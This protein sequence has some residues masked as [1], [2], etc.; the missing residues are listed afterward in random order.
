M[1]LTQFCLLFSSLLLL[2]MCGQQ[3]FQDNPNSS[4]VSQGGSTATF[5]TF[6]DYF[7]IIDQSSLHTYNVANENKISFLNTLYLGAQ[8][9]ETIFPFGDYLFL[10]STT[11]IYIVDNSNPDAPVYLSSYE[12]VV[13][14]D[15][16]VTDGD[17]AYV[18]LRSGNN[19]GRAQDLLLILDLSE[20]QNPQLIATY[21]LDSPQG[22]AINDDILYVSDNGIRILDVSDKS[23]IQEL[24]FV[25]NIPAND[26]IYHNDILLVTADDGFYQFDVSDVNNVTQLGQFSF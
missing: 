21:D 5:A 20:I 19:C 8:Q 22:L 3:D 6:G 16:V 4:A 26:V 23:N 12:H 2:S 24:A 11:G 7:Y 1:R 25:A 14:C 17:F 13:S 10:G 18:T 9:L 15:P